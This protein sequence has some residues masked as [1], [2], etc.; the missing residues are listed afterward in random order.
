MQHSGRLSRRRFLAG[1]IGAATLAAGVRGIFTPAMAH[2]DPP[3]LPLPITAADGKP[4]LDPQQVRRYAFNHYFQGG[5]MHGAASGLMQ[6]FKEA[7]QENGTGWDMLPYGMYKYGSGG[8][9][10]WG[11]LCGIL[12]GCMAV[13][14]LI[15]LHNALGN[16]LMGWYATTLFPTDR[17]DGF[18]AETGQA[19]LPDAEVLAR[20]VSDSPLCHI[21][22]GKWCRAAGVGIADTS[23]EGIR[24]KDDRCSKVCADSAAKTAALINDYVRD[25]DV[26]EPFATPE[27]YANCLEC[28]TTLKDQVG[29]MDCLGCHLPGDVVTVSRRH[30]ASGR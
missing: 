6:A 21:S 19:A 14:N 5:C 23:P 25:A 20:T 18:V 11:T 9:A 13:L 15:G 7:F 24:Y 22:I 17:C 4:V 8:V 2:A 12:N 10:G 3:T 26:A 30:P 29:R 16:D 28:H 1:G 27:S